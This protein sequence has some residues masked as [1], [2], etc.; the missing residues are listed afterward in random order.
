MN[1]R[2][3]LKSIKWIILFVVT[4]VILAHVFWYFDWRAKDKVGQNIP[5]EFPVMVVSRS[6][7]TSGYQAAIVKYADLQVYIGNLKDYSF[8]VPEGEEETLTKQ[9]ALK[10]PSSGLYGLYP[11]KVL[12]RGHGYQHIEVV[13]LHG[14]DSVRRAWYIAKP[15]QVEPLYYR[16]SF[17]PPIMVFVFS[18]P[19]ALLVNIIAWLLLRFAYNVWKRKSVK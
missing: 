3:T 14:S 9:V 12:K 6:N 2:L 7:T 4:S 1:P 19:V 5:K 18:M 8:L 15:R 17:L 13:Q 10:W 16:Y 11:F